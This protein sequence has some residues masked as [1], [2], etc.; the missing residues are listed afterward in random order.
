MGEVFPLSD[1]AKILIIRRFHCA[2]RFATRTKSNFKILT[3][4]YIA[5]ATLIFS[6]YERFHTQLVWVIFSLKMLDSKM[7]IMQA[8][9]CHRKSEWTLFLKY[10]GLAIPSFGLQSRQLYH[11]IA[12]MCTEKILDEIL[13]IDDSIPSLPNLPQNWLWK[14]DMSSFLTKNH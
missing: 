8:Y 3:H 7:A 1:W 13:T 12:K 9:L 10:I 11:V 6:S 5:R 14:G 2:R 4:H